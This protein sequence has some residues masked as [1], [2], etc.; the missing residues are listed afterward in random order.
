MENTPV[1]LHLNKTQRCLD[2]LNAF[3]YKPDHTFA[4]ME[5]SIK[6]SSNYFDEYII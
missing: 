1:L 4:Y 6:W 2:I 5:I 3:V